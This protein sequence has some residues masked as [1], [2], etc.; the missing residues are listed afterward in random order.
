MFR[1][2][3]FYVLIFLPERMMRTVRSHVYVS[4]SRAET[5]FRTNLR[6]RF[7]YCNSSFLTLSSSLLPSCFA[8]Q[9]FE[10]D[11]AKQ[12]DKMR[13]SAFYL[14]SFVLSTVYLR[15]FCHGF[16]S[17]SVRMLSTTTATLARPTSHLMAEQLNVAFVTGNQVRELNAVV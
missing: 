4:N 1:F 3:Q 7:R 8:P 9:T 12:S 16:V 14:G 10:K 6:I 13:L 2:V 17:S 5:L 11:L 15:L